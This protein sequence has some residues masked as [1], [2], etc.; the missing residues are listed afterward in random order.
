MDS[1][2][3]VWGMSTLLKG[4]RGRMQALQSFAYQSASRAARFFFRDEGS[5][6]R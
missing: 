2:L 3:S 1:V 5:A 6:A 4:A